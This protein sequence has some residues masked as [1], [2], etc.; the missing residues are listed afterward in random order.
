M[1]FDV[2]LHHHS[3][4]KCI[5]KITFY[6]SAPPHE[7]GIYNSLNQIF[8]T[9][10]QYLYPRWHL[11]WL[12]LTLNASIAFSCVSTWR[13]WHHSKP[14][15]VVWN[16]KMTRVNLRI[17]I[18]HS[19]NLMMDL[20]KNPQG[21]DVNGCS[22]SS[23]RVQSVLTFISHYSEQKQLSELYLALLLPWLHIAHLP[24]LLLKILENINILSVRDVRQGTVQADCVMENEVPLSPWWVR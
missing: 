2:A 13:V 4:I 16:L 6:I 12:P 1:W 8:H 24:P 20:P 11:L 21:W 15:N 5:S 10:I 9:Y 19:R 17:D 18:P 3:G 7:G 14:W 22:V 23:P